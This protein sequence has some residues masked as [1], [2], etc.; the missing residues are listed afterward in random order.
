MRLGISPHAINKVVG[1]ATINVGPVMDATLQQ[2]A[3]EL[4]AKSD[5]YETDV[6][7][8]KELTAAAASRIIQGRVHDAVGGRAREAA[9][10]EAEAASQVREPR[11]GPGGRAPY[12]QEGDARAARPGRHRRVGGD[13]AVADV[14]RAP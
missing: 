6:A 14:R 13:A 5:K 4:R 9:Q 11:E 2:M 1:A 3:N 7:D 8:F 12:Q 10:R